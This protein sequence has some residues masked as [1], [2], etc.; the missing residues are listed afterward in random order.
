MGKIFNTP[1]DMWETHKL[2][3]ELK[4]SHIHR[5]IEYTR[6]KNNPYKYANVG[7]NPQQPYISLGQK[8]I[9]KLTPN[10]KIA[11]KISQK[12]V[13]GPVRCYV[14]PKTKKN[15]IFT[16]IGENIKDRIHYI[17]EDLADFFFGEMQ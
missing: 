2:M 5:A 13:G 7:Y 17:K 11:K 16:R 8:I 15:T 3:S 12:A 1:R 14:P 10:G 6:I 9:K 4:N